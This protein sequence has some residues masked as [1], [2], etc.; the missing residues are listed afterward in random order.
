MFEKR[1]LAGRPVNSSA[2]RGGVW[3]VDFFAAYC[4]P[5]HDRFAV[6]RAVSQEAAVVGVSVDEDIASAVAQVRRF[7][8]PFFVIHDPAHVLAGKFRVAT[9]PMTFVIDATNCVAWVADARVAREQFGA[10]LRQNIA[11]AKVKTT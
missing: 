11:A 1:D 4:A 6:L 10:G 8:L 7:A 3:I 9:L 2:L 5:C